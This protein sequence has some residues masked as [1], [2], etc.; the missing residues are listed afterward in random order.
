MPIFRG[1]LFVALVFLIFMS[2]MIPVG[3]SDISKWDIARQEPEWLRA[4]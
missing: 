3:R 4:K 1:I 2:I